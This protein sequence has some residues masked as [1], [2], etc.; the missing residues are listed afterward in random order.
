MAR[1]GKNA[2]LSLWLCCLVAGMTGLAFASVPLYRLFCQV[3]GFGGTPMV[4]AA[5]PAKVIDRV[6][7]VRFNADT[8]PHLPWRFR[9]EQTSVKVHAGARHLVF[10]RAEN[11]S[12]RPVAGTATF[13]VT[14]EKA[15]KYFH[16]TYCFCF[17][18]QWLGAGQHAYL[19]VSFYVDP[20]IADDKNMADVHTITLSYTFFRM[21]NAD[22]S[23]KPEP[24]PQAGKAA[25][26]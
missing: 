12:D 17:E 26:N 15:G 16:K 18:E 14:P 23:A 21:K 1:L 13:N 3:T 24:K 8:D 10:Y 19:P 11:Q 7:T 20:A 2:R 4:S 22:E 6:V 9:P 5:A 25:V